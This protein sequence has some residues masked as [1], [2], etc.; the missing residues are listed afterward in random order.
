MPESPQIPTEPEIN[1]QG[2]KPLLLSFIKDLSA[3][4]LTELRSLFAQNS[5]R[6]N[7]YFK[8]IEGGKYKVI[9]TS[10]LVE[11]NQQL[12]QKKQKKFAKSIKI[13]S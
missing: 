9:K 7:V 11:N 2:S 6:D 3:N 12:K 1:N 8:I 5:G 4:E 10:F 13:T